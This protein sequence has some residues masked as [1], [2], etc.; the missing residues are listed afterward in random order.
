M[1]LYSYAPYEDEN[2]KNQ[3]EL[4]Y[5]SDDEFQSSIHGPYYKWYHKLYQIICFFLFLGPLRVIISFSSLIIIGV[6]IIAAH[7]ILRLLNMDLDKYRHINYNIG[8]IGVRL[9]IWGLGVGWIHIDGDWDPEARF[10]CCNHIGFIEPLVIVVSK[11]VS[12]VLKK[13][14][15]SVPFISDII[16]IIDPI[17]VD[18]TKECGLTKA[19]SAQAHNLK[20]DP[21]MIFPEGAIS[22]GNYMLKFHRSAFLDNQKVQPVCVRFYTPFCPK[23]WNTFYWLDQ[24]GLGLICGLF[25]MPFSYCK[26]TLLPAFKEDPD[27]F[28]PEE[29]AKKC[30][31]MMANELGIKAVSRSSNELYR[32]K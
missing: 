15:K 13:D 10:V 23:G 28:S 12:A 20:K 31:L 21:I 16:D 14:F 18:R 25:A 2:Y 11:N 27:N 3:K 22:N 7:K 24:S 8:C 26:V 17:Y 6:V 29:M 9:F 30:Q 5:I 32:V 19:V 1:V 4:T